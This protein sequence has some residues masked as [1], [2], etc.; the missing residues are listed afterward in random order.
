MLELP[1][2]DLARRHSLEYRKDLE[3][4]TGSVAKLGASGS[5]SVRDGQVT[6]ELHYPFI[7]PG[8]LRRKVE[9]SIEQHLDQL[10]A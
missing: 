6:V 3:K 5:Y 10:F 7:L 4:R 9:Q 1:V 2:G 8:A